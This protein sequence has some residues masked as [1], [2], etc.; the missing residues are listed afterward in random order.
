M[1][2]SKYNESQI[3]GI[4]E[5]AD[6]SVPVTDLIRLVQAVYPSDV[7]SASTRGAVPFLCFPRA[8]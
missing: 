5:E 3:V 7:S 4:L 6:A 8:L 2:K 1:R